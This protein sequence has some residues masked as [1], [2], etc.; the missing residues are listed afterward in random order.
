[1]K[2]CKAQLPDGKPC[3]NQ[4]DEGQEYCPF[5]LADQITMPKKILSI[6]LPVLGVVASTVVA[7]VLKHLADS[8]KRE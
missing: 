1:M 5:H 7:A 4:A 2:P 6:A 3:P 8:S